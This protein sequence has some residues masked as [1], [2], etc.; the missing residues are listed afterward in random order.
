MSAYLA[1]DA[2]SKD[3]VEPHLIYFLL[4][5]LITNFIQSGLLATGHMDGDFVPDE[6]KTARFWAIRVSFYF[7]PRSPDLDQQTSSFVQVL[8]MK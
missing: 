4:I 3:E 6:L 7:Q 2:G 1:P 8:K 5:S